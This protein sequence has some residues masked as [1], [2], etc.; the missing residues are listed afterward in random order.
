MRERE[1]EMIEEK[2]GRDGAKRWTGKE[3]GK[4]NR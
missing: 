1:N 4:R 3:E 2:S